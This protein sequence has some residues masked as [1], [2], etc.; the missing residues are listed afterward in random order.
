[1]S[2]IS[3]YFTLH[4]ATKQ[5]SPPPQHNTCYTQFFSSSVVVVPQ[6]QDHYHQLSHLIHVHNHHTFLLLLCCC[7]S[8]QHHLFIENVTQSCPLHVCRLG[9]LMFL[10]NPFIVCA[11]QNWI[12]MCVVIAVRPS[13]FKVKSWVP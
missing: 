5:C 11:F 12:T 7:S 3:L 10:P 6:V 2:C 9:T 8:L 1:M 4:H 13:Y